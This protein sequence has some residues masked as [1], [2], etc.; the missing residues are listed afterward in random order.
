M[1]SSAASKPRRRRPLLVLACVLAVSVAGLEVAARAY[2]ALQNGL[3]QLWL[4]S[5]RAFSLQKR[6]QAFAEIYVRGI[7]AKP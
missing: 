7:V 4:L 2:L 1:P 3:V 5:P 6:A